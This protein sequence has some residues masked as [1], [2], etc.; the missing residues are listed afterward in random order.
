[1]GSSIRMRVLLISD[2]Q[3][4][5]IKRHVQCLR[6]CLPTEVEHYTIGEDE[7]FAGKNGHD[8]REF[9][10]ICRVIRK[11]KPDIVHFH[12]PNFL[13]ALGARVLGCKFVCSWHTPT[14][15]R[16]SIKTRVFFWLLGRK[17]YFL[18][19]SSATWEGLKNWL[20]YAKG[21]VFYNPLKID[22][23]QGVIMEDNGR[24]VIGLLGRFADQKIGGAS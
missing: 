2:R 23:I 22:K 11:F 8:W 3:D 16:M 14:N 21:E 15:H 19:V 13:M 7:P 24:F 10:Q 5:G 18:P 20:P 9:V 17:C 12:T 4:G 1:M 6:N